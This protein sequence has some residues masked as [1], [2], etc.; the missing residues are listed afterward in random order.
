L[1]PQT[2]PAKTPSPD[3][4][5]SVSFE[6]SDKGL[7]INIQADKSSDKELE[8]EVI[9]MIREWRFLAALRNG[10][11]VVSQ[12]YVDLSGGDSAGRKRPVHRR[13]APGPQ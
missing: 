11:P 13:A 10:T 1:A 8:E 9:A 4:F 12:A 6:I 5:V 2:I 3:S 7:P